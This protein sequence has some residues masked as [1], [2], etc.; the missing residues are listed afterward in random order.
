MARR[1][2]ASSPNA[3]S[4]RGLPPAPPPGVGIGGRYLVVSGA[5]LL[6]VVEAT[7]R[8]PKISRVVEEEA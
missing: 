5:E 8:G 1:C 6:A 7:P 4:V 3:L 2:A